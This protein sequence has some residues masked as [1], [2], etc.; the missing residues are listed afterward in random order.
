MAWYSDPPACTRCGGALTHDG[1]T[2]RCGG[3][4]QYAAEAPTRRQLLSVAE[5]LAVMELRRDPGGYSP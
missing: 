5:A 2:C 3:R 4:S 1:E